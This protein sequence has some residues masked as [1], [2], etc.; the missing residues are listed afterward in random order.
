MQCKCSCAAATIDRTSTQALGFANLTLCNPVRPGSA[1][2][3]RHQ[4]HASA[5][6]L[7]R[8]SFFSSQQRTSASAW[9]ASFLSAP[10]GFSTAF[11]GLVFSYPSKS[12]GRPLRNHLIPTW[13]SLSVR[14]SNCHVALESVSR[15]M[16]CLPLGP[17][18]GELLCC[19]LTARLGRVIGGRVRFSVPG[20]FSFLYHAFATHPLIVVPRPA[21]SHD[22]PSCFP[23][24]S[25][26]FGT[27]HIAD[28]A[29]RA[30]A[31][32]I[33][34]ASAS[35]SRRRRGF[36]RPREGHLA[37]SIEE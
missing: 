31:P 20:A 34:F 5:S 36:T 27:L 15:G 23:S 9:P 6:S 26:L 2:L 35:G 12:Q 30:G 10:Y 24:L 22:S 11:R 28:A 4:S 13:S 21:R 33:S 1:P 37:R 14:K 3:C 25:T 7:A 32:H 19:T 17:L 8:V 16:G 29:S 18:R